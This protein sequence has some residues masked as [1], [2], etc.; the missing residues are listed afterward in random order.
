MIITQDNWLFTQHISQTFSSSQFDYDVTI[1]V[2]ATYSVPSCR[3][4]QGCR[5]GFNLL[6]YMTNTI[7]LPSTQGSGFM[8]TQIYALFAEPYAPLTSVTYT[9]TYNFTLPSSSTGFYIAAQDTGS[10]IAVSRL[11]VFRNNCRA[12]Q[13]GL[14]LYPDTPAPVSGVAI[15]SVS[16]VDNAVISGSAQV[17]CASDGTWGPE[18]PVCQCSPAFVD[19]MVECVGKYSFWLHLS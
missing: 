19:N 4:R 17:T 3:E 7:Q 16:C 12:R 8:N 11:R 1:F 6:H 10:C 14:I 5:Q 9:N 15:I 18:T 2:E 13:V